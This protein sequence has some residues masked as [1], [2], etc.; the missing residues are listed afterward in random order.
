M[1][2]SALQQN[3]KTNNK[4]LALRKMN[5]AFIVILLENTKVKEMRQKNSHE[6]LLSKEKGHVKCYHC[7]DFKCNFH[8][9]THRSLNIPDTLSWGQ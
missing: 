6:F 3:N 2:R 1:V 7:K 5:K 8:S 4:A 9:V